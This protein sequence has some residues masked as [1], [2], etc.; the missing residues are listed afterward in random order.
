MSTVIDLPGVPF[1]LTPSAVD[2]WRVDDVGVVVATAPGHTDLFVDPGGEHT[3]G[4]ESMLNAVTLLGDPPAGDF[5][6]SAR[7]GVDFVA[8]FD[9]GVLLVWLDETHWAKLCFEQSPSG[10]PMVVS[11]VTRGTSDDANGFVV[12]GEQV[13]LRISRIGHVHAFHASLDGQVWELVRVFA[14][15]QGS[16]GV[17]GHRLGLEVQAPTG[18]GC[19]ATFAQVRFT[20]TTL[21]DLRDGS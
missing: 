8:R 17:T 16:D 20:P 18:D 13:W 3:V 9:A 7:V 2:A 12:E 19:T 15:G 5:Q 4:A 1:V 10:A 11:V 21:G 14:L 6:L